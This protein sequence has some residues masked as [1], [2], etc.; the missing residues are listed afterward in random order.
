MRCL[1]FFMRPLHSVSTYFCPHPKFNWQ[2]SRSAGC[3]VFAQ[4]Q[5]MISKKL[6]I[7]LMRNQLCPSTPLS[8][9]W[10]KKVYVMAPFFYDKHNA[11]LLK[12]PINHSTTRGNLELAVEP[13]GKM[14]QSGGKLHLG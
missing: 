3:D 9:F 1:T 14:N 7:I 4:L 12:N 5:N 8:N 13:R 2:I 6:T 10:L 11:S